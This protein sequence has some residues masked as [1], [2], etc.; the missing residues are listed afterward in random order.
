[1][2]CAGNENNCWPGVGC[3][4][5]V[6]RTSLQGDCLADVEQLKCDIVKRNKRTL[7]NLERSCRMKSTSF[8][9]AINVTNY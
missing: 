2:E 5:S 6:H 4:R 8:D 1:M 9:T 7:T 3:F